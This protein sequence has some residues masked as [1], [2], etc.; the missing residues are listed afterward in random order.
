MVETRSQASAQRGNETHVEENEHNNGSVTKGGDKLEESEAKEQRAV[1]RVRKEDTNSNEL[2]EQHESESLSVTYVG[3]S[4]ESKPRLQNGDK[5][6]EG[7]INSFG[8]RQPKLSSIGR[9]G[10]LGEYKDAEGLGATPNGAIP[11]KNVVAPQSDPFISLNKLTTNEDI[12]SWPL[13]ALVQIV[14]KIDSEEYPMEKSHVTKCGPKLLRRLMMQFR[15]ELVQHNKN[16]KVGSRVKKRAGAF[17]IDTKEWEIE[18]YDKEDLSIILREYMNHEDIVD[19]KHELSTMSADE[20]RDYLFQFQDSMMDAEIVPFNVHTNFDYFRGDLEQAIK[21]FNTNMESTI[22]ATTPSSEP[23]F[24]GS[25]AGTGQ[26][27]TR[28][29]DSQVTSDIMSERSPSKAYDGKSDD[30]EIPVNS[31]YNHMLSKD[32]H[33]ML[34][35]GWS[36]KVLL[37]FIRSRAKDY[38]LFLPFHLLKNCNPKFLRRIVRDIRDEMVENTQMDVYDS[39]V[40]VQCSVF[41]SDTAKWELKAYDKQ[42][43]N[44]IC[45]KFMEMSKLV[46]PEEFSDWDKDMVV[47]FLWKSRKKMKKDELPSL[48]VHVHLEC[49]EGNV[50]KE[51]ADLVQQNDPKSISTNDYFMLTALSFDDKINQWSPGILKNFIHIWRVQ[52]KLKLKIETIEKLPAK[53]LRGVVYQIR[54]ELKKENK[55]NSVHVEAEFWS[56]LHPQ[57]QQWEVESFHWNDQ[58]ALLNLVARK[59]NKGFEVD[60]MTR[61]ECVSCIMDLIKSQTFQEEKLT[62]CYKSEPMLPVTQD[63]INKCFP[64]S[65][66]SNT[67]TVSFSKDTCKHDMRKWSSKVLVALIHRLQPKMENK[68]K[69]QLIRE[70]VTH[71][72]ELV[73]RQLKR[74][75]EHQLQE[76]HVIKDERSGFFGELT[77]DWEINGYTQV[78][79]QDLLQQ[80]R[81]YLE[82][83]IPRSE[84][85]SLIFLKRELKQT[86]DF[87]KEREDKT[88]FDLSNVQHSVVTGQ[89][90]RMKPS[91]SMNSEMV[92]YESEPK[93]QTKNSIEAYSQ[94]S[95]QELLNI[96]SEQFNDVSKGQEIPI[97]NCVPTL[98]RE[99]TDVQI[100]SWP[101]KTRMEILQQAGVDYSEQ[102]CMEL[103]NSLCKVRN[104]MNPGKEI[105]ALNP[106]YGFFGR[107][108]KDSKLW[109]L[110]EIDI[111]RLYIHHCT[112]HGINLELQFFDSCSKKDILEEMQL[113]RALWLQKLSYRFDLCIHLIHSGNV[114]VLNT[115]VQEVYTQ[116]VRRIKAAD[117]QR[118]RSFNGKKKKK[119]DYGSSMVIPETESHIM[120]LTA[121]WEIRNMSR[122]EAIKELNYQCELLHREVPSNDQL[123]SMEMSDIV[124]KLLE[125]RKI[126]VRIYQ[127][128]NLPAED[129]NTQDDLMSEALEDSSRMSSSV[130]EEDA[131]DDLSNESTEQ[132]GNDD[133]SCDDSQLSQDRS[134][135]VTQSDEESL[136]EESSN[137]MDEQHDEDSDDSDSEDESV[138]ETDQDEMTVQDSEFQLVTSKKKKKKATEKGDKKKRMVTQA[139][140]DETNSVTPMEVTSTESNEESEMSYWY[141]RAKMGVN[142]R[143]AHVP[144]ML[145]KLVRVLREHDNSFQILPFD[146]NDPLTS[147]TIIV[148]EDQFPDTEAYIRDWVRG[149]VIT[150]SRK[151][152]FS[153]RITTKKTLKHFKKDIYEIIDAN[154]WYINFDSVCAESVYLLGWIKGIHPRCHR[155][156]LVKKFIEDRIPTLK[157]KFHV[158]F[159]GVWAT[160]DKGEEAGTE[161]LAVEGAFTERSY[162][163]EEISKLH[164]NAAYGDALFVP[165]QSSKAFTNEH[166]ISAYGQ[167]NTFLKTT[168]SKTVFLQE[169]CRLGHQNGHPLYFEHWIIN[170]TV[171]H[172]RFLQKVESYPNN[173]VRLI[174]HCD[175]EHMVE[176]ALANLFANVC[177]DF[178]M[179][180]A[181]TLLGP[182]EKHLQ[183]LAAYN[184]RNKLHQ[185][186]AKAIE[187]SR[188]K[189]TKVVKR[190]KMPTPLPSPTT[191]KVSYASVTN[192]QV[193]QTTYNGKNKIMESKMENRLKELEAKMSQQVFDE[194]K[195]TA[196]IQQSLQKDIE[197]TKKDLELKMKQDKE[198]TL[199][200]ISKS[201]QKLEKKIDDKVLVFSDQLKSI[202]NM[203][204]DTKAENEVQSSSVERMERNQSRILHALEAILP[205]ANIQT[206]LKPPV[207]AVEQSS[208]HGV[209]R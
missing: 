19:E 34:I 116:I 52:G 18:A 12:C 118:E 8:L 203:L 206:K 6:R 186:C 58:K 42:D 43:L 127:A 39:K 92:I 111:K 79:L 171:D 15:D 51:I 195:V 196:Q 156:D 198:D 81:K 53:V 114:Q 109:S 146:V 73:L 200:A 117:V 59:L 85:E 143:S 80:T 63:I 113:I 162:I 168:R 33:D 204:W 173:S 160:D 100:G 153:L 154:D 97:M 129:K 16:V 151:L 134:K 119:I 38:E 50:E 159:R 130:M 139:K 201:E 147:D 55:N 11:T 7:E 96:Y 178:S 57:T 131:D 144:S 148:H 28:D 45:L 25:T 128:M 199:A 23:N 194:K 54:N 86:R 190:S 155:K 94:Y 120:G 110:N 106:F 60:D 164:W 90:K 136:D 121:E 172:V 4:T 27:P 142:T 132:S 13:Q 99:T 64:Q 30:D 37:N 56:T 161:A 149:S 181:I 183:R 137:D 98:T 3:S 167:Q 165:M 17:G 189:E 180:I 133:V 46:V 77:L 93:V 89:Q 2:E 122:E 105:A 193:S 48:R 163:M 82:G 115:S 87:L 174:Y 9:G 187:S 95:K 78:E 126:H 176:E 191:S 188:T 112:R 47:K 197:E 108:T 61:E 83:A 70:P 175:F 179:E 177:N 35:K 209:A 91:S 14:L 49:F 107:S 124:D 62:I 44:Q 145:K 123:S 36:A 32:T 24:S 138:M 170:K 207:S 72:R 71:L 66:Q 76:S 10:G 1:K 157:N 88:Y 192:N 184:K 104:T 21:D 41:H 20:I 68:T 185:K 140:S 169:N 150:R 125:F 135:M 40:N 103:F 166:I 69:F 152:C 102:D 26:T 101:P 22:V 75:Q 74:L 67:T 31:K 182:E 141:L 202:T 84:N 65:A 5:Y 158:Y 205:P 29:H 208:C